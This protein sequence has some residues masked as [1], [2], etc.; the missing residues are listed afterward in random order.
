VENAEK[1]RVARLLA[2]AEPFSSLAP[3]VMDACAARF[4][5]ARFANGQMIFARG[6]AGTHL[7]VVDAGQVR[8][9][10][11]TADGRELSF[12]IAAE[13]D[14][15]GEIAVLDGGPRSAEAT[16]LVDTVA[17]GLSREEFRHL[18]ATHPDVADA[19]VAYLC[20]RLR[21]VSEKLEG[22][23]LYPLEVRLARFLVAMIG[24]RT[25]PS[26]SRV[27]LEL[28]FSQSELALLLGATRAKTNG[29]LKSL[30]AA[31]ALKR[32]ADRLFCD[33]EA[34]AALARS[35]EPPSE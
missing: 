26:G 22:I 19:V 5:K 16:A 14:L 2:G 23:A 24:D 33:P 27:P 20:R 18:R 32:T 21:E 10:V 7:Y 3:D 28:R 29:A 11:S 6:D 8:L 1:H 12:Q 4:R 30:E 13:G 17:Y 15:F 34:L 35:F 31:S 25:S 9:A